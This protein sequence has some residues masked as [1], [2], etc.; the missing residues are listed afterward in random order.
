MI[1][2]ISITFTARG[3]YRLWMLLAAFMLMPLPAFS[4][5]SAY[6]EGLVHEAK[7][8]KL[9]EDRGWKTLLHYGKNLS[10]ADRSKIDDK[11]FSSLL[12]A[13]PTPKQS[14]NQP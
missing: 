3:A 6:V 14:S 2:L 11:N 4:Q 13:E 10:G 5:D 12:T 8:R 1:P 9:H 7:E